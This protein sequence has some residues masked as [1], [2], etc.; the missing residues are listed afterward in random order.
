MVR[1]IVLNVTYETENIFPLTLKLLKII[2][3]SILS[4]A[5]TGPIL[6]V[7]IEVNLKIKQK[8]NPPPP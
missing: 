3:S 4:K 1:V 2:L 6:G 5:C 8:K 7:V